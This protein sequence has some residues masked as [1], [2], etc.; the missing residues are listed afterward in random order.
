MIQK[1][2]AEKSLSAVVSL[3]RPRAVFALFRAELAL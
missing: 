2:A 1:V 3:V